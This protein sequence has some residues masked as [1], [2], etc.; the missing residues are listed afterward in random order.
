LPLRYLASIFS[1]FVLLI[2]ATLLRA[3]D[4]D[5][6]LKISPQAERLRPFSDPATL[7]IRV[8][9]PDGRAVER[10]WV[11][12]RTE[13]PKQSWL[14]STD[15][16]VV[17]G[18]ALLEMQL[19]LMEG[20]AEWKYLFPIRGVY[21]ITIDAMTPDGSQAGR[22]FQIAIR[23]NEEKWL[24]L[25]VL[26]VCLFASGIVAGR[27]FTRTQTNSTVKLSACLLISVCFLGFLIGRTPAQE[28]KLTGHEGRL[29]IDPPTVGKMSHVRWVL[30]SPGRDDKMNGR[31]MLTITH[32]EKGKTVFSVERL[33]VAGE[34]S[35]QFQ[36]TDGDEYRVAALAYLASGET[37]RTGKTVS[38]TPVEP[39]MRAMIPALAFFLA[40]IALG[41][42]VGRWSKLAGAAP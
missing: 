1:C 9:K 35:L 18:S 11:T 19:P 37:L 2:F 27:I 25:S 39:P 33:P 41:L 13:A 10:G 15:F 17:E 34:F 36:F 32:M 30:A 5:I 12:I 22:N 24:L 8:A 42:G 38:V 23:E 31:L 7:T 6:Q 14:F 20:K 21:R 4:L 16:P 26:T 29:E 3:E 40:V 28:K